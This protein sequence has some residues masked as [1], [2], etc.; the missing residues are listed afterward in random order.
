L[1][2]ERFHLVGHDV[3]GIVGWELACRHPHRLLTFTVASTPHLSPFSLALTDPSSTRV[4]PFG[5]FRQ[6]TP[7]PETALLADDAALLRAGYIGLDPE[8]IDTYLRSFAAA[9]TLTAALNYF[10]AFNFDEWRDLP[11]TDVPTLFV[12]GEEDPYLATATAEATAHHVHG[13][14]RAEALAGVGHW[15]AELAAN[16]LTRLLLE[17]LAA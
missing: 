1:G 9:G 8:S 4:P 7:L 3:G 11:A 13:P 17:H 5:L 15:V 2:A 14:Y 16:T 12:W 6:P 10:R